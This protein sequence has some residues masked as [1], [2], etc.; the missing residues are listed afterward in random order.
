MELNKIKST[1]ENLVSDFQIT[2]VILVCFL[3][4][5]TS[6]STPVNNCSHPAAPASNWLI[7]GSVHQ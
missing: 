5:L 4:L 1:I 7:F 2:S 3:M 6:T